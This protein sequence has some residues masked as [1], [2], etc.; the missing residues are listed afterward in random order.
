MRSPCPLHVIPT[1]AVAVLLIASLA[2]AQQYQQ[3]PGGAQQLPVQQQFQ[4]AQAQAQQAQAQQA[5][6]GP[7][8]LS[9][10]EQAQLDGILVQ[11]Q[12]RSQAVKNFQCKFTRWEFDYVFGPS[13]LAHGDKAKYRTLSTGELKYE[14]PDKGLFRVDEMLVW[15]PK[16]LEPNAPAPV[17]PQGTYEKPQQDAN[18]QWVCDG[19]LVYQF[20]PVNK[21]VTQY[22][23]PPAMQGKA[24]ADGPLPFLFGAD[25]A[26]LK[27]RY[28]MKNVTEPDAQGQLWLEAWPKWQQ[29]AANFRTATII[30]DTNTF[31]PLAMQIDDPHA[32]TLTKRT[33]Y[34][35]T[36]VV[37]NK[38][39]W[40]HRGFSVPRTP[41]G[42]KKVV[43]EAPGVAAGQNA[44]LNR[45][46]PQANRTQQPQGS[47]RR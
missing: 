12:T 31:L 5:Q 16:P 33:R 2:F 17:V 21:T 37:E 3:Q 9:P 15:T 46:A 25:A 26:K 18:E 8:T 19:K 28:W 34:V 24:I 32:G 45:Q 23:L 43:Q 30:L 36:D 35:F 41:F 10:Q 20:D 38:S 14:A 22:T 11:W 1:L 7:F 47:M 42:W 29:D 39:G 40:F 27:A 44:P 6:K 13:V 4:P